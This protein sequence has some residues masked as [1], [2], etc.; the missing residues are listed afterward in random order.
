[1]EVFFI[2]ITLT[3][4]VVLFFG[5]SALGSHISYTLA[6]KYAWGFGDYFV[7]AALITGLTWSLIGGIISACI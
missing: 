7:V 4:L 6:D 3:G 2:G 5:G 1:M